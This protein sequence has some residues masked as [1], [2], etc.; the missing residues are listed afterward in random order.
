M[1]AGE[2]VRLLQVELEYYQQCPDPVR[3][4]LWYF[5]FVRGLWFLAFV[6]YHLHWPGC[7]FVT[8]D[9]NPLVIRGAYYKES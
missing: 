9:M 4:T 3:Q 8:S 7:L 6:R 2:H 5:P 1:Y